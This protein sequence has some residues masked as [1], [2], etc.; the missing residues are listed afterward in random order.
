MKCASALPKGKITRQKGKITKQLEPAKTPELEYM[1]QL[2]LALGTHHDVRI[3]RQNCGQIPVRDHTGKVLR[4]FDA[5]PPNGAADISGFVRPEGWRL[6]IETKAAKGKPSKAQQI[7]ARNVAAG[8]CVYVLV[9]YE[10]D[11]TVEENVHCAVDQ[12]ER[13]I[14]CKRREEET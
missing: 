14:A 10:A 2:M 13:A 5:G 4:V 6:E 9:G 7:F 1:R 3:W 8:G 12:V 11:R